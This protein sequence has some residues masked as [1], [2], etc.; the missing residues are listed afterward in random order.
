MNVPSHKSYSVSYLHLIPHAGTLISNTLNHIR[1]K[2]KLFIYLFY[3][4]LRQ[5][6][7]VALEPCIPG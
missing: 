6:S 3:W 7:S 4:F 1:M 2:V 5:H